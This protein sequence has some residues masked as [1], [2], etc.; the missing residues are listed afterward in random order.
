[1]VS[2]NLCFRGNFGWVFQLRNVRA[3]ASLIKLPTV[4]RAHDGVALYATTTERGASVYTNIARCMGIS[5][6]IAPNNQRFAK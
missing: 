2:S 1:M 3:F 5:G 4:V 6:T